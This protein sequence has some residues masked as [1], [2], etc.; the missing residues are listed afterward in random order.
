MH[1][2]R[3]TVRE[4]RSEVPERQRPA[5][6]AAEFG[7]SIF[8]LVRAG[9]AARLL[10]L[11]ERG[12]PPG[13]SNDRGDSLLLVASYH[14]HHDVAQALL[15]HGADPDTPNALGQ[16]PLEGATFKGD[17]EMVDL[18]LQHGALV[19]VPASEG[20][21]ALMVAAMFDR[22]DV[23]D[24]LLDHGAD[25]LARDVQGMTAR[26]LAARMGAQGALGRLAM[27]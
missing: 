10:P 12:V 19:D 2:S 11:L 23:L 5:N 26:D 4:R 24:L 17:A 22:V 20:K 16:T 7:D 14:G 15:D 21:T 9:D 13:L 27:A 3:R 6:E 1:V 18:L 8:Q 25:P